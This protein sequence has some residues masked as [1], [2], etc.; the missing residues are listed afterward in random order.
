MA[1]ILNKNRFAVTSS[2]IVG[3]RGV[4]AGAVVV[5]HG[6]IVAIE[7]RA[8]SGVPTYDAGPLAVMPGLVDTHVHVNEPGRTDWEGYET[9]TRAAAA[10]GITTLVDMP[11]NC[12]PVTTS[13]SALE[14][15]LRAL[16]GKL[17]VDCGFYGGLVPG[18]TAEIAP[19]VRRGVL[20]FKCF[21]VHSGIDD[22]PQVGGKDLDVFMPE[23]ARCGVPLLV[24]AEIESEVPALASKLPSPYAA[25]LASRP[26]SWENRAV[27]MMIERCR[28]TR[29]RTHIVH[30]SSSDCVPLIAAARSQGLPFS[31]ETCPHYLTFTA[32]EVKAG[33][34]RFKCAPPIR[35]R[36][37]RE[38]LWDGLRERAISCVVSD[39]S[40]CAPH[41]KKSEEGDFH[42]AW[43][44]ISGL[45]FGLGAIWAG[46]GERGFGLLDLARWMAE[47]P[48]AM[49]GLGARKGRLAPG[50]DADLVIFDPD[51]ILTVASDRIHHRHKVTPYEGR[52]L[53]GEA[54]AT[55][56]RGTLVYE[57][58]RFLRTDAGV[59]L[60][61]DS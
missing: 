17:A 52:A 58:G 47:E 13:L 53:R 29:C 21:L 57:R 19:M 11:L 61:K 40:P 15:K 7:R 45:Q 33:D 46:A 9:A 14:E 23:L 55:F 26:R 20:G 4:E 8:P 51:K 41:L 16:A 59:P 34:T 22:F 24:H 18:N 1:T 44:G 43:G 38:L 54:V 25:Y 35:E 5:E 31:A 48:A 27:A 12:I 49:V 60:L 50:Y 37:N 10:G 39:H 42:A 2:R 6:R 56:V 3:D 30:L 36:E 32:E 28:A